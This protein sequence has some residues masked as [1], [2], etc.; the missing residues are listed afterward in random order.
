MRILNL[1]DDMLQQICR[2][3]RLC[4]CCFV[5]GDFSLPRFRDKLLHDLLCIGLR[6]LKLFDLVQPAEFSG[7]YRDRN[8]RHLSA[9]GT[10]RRLR[11]GKLQNAV[12]RFGSLFLFR[13][14]QCSGFPPDRS[15]LCNRR[16]AVD[17]RFL[18]RHRILR[19]MQKFIR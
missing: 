4:L 11:C 13:L 14:L 2:F 15:C 6:R 9:N 8:R 16:A 1:C 5:L 3:N 10:L 17:Q 19:G 7:R 12:C 18:G